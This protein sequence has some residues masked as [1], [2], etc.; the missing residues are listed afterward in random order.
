M[1]SP[2]AANRVMATFGGA[3]TTMLKVQESVRALASVAVQTTAVV[4]I[5]NEAPLDGL[6]EIVTDG[7]PPCV[8]AVPN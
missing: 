4:P 6:Q 5:A 8:V 1:L 3:A 2:N 7:A